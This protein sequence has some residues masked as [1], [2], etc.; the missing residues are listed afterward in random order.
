[1]T[2]ATTAVTTVLRQP[3]ER[4][5]PPYFVAD[6]G[7]EACDDGNEVNTDACVDCEHAECGD[8]IVRLDL[9]PGTE[10]MRAMMATL[11]MPMLV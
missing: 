7:Y 3:C 6:V 10:V 5:S 1:M 9:A 4:H 2:T 8:Q 11:R